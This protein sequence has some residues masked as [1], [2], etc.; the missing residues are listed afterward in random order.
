[1]KSLTMED[2]YR[3]SCDRCR[4]RFC[5]PC[6]SERSRIVAA[7]VHDHIKDRTVRFITLTLRSSNAALDQCVSRLYDCFARL[8]RRKCWSCSQTGGAV[9]LEIKWSPDKQ[10]WHPHLHIISEGKFLDVRELSM[11]WKCITGDSFIVDIRIVK[12]SKQA[13][14]YVAKYAS[15]GI[16]GAYMHDPAKLREAIKCLSG[17]RL[18]ATFG[19]WRGLK[20]LE[21]KVEDDWECIGN[22]N[23]FLIRC[24]KGELGVTTILKKLGLTVSTNERDKPCQISG[25]AP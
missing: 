6:A 25:P 12:Q 9:F 4:D 8:K 5:V 14:Q 24:R 19:D 13:A 16:G 2:K 7:N 1:M 15:K 20:L 21:Q 23:D 17:R 3:I 22:L 10:Q 11:H 18:L